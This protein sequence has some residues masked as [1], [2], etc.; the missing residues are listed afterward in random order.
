M[1]AFQLFCDSTSLAVSANA[2]PTRD[3][4]ALLEQMR[5]AVDAGDPA[6]ANCET[7]KDYAAI[8]F[9]AMRKLEYGFATQAFAT[10][11]AESAHALRVLDVGSGVVPLCNWM[12]RR[13]HEVTA[14]DPARSDIEFLISSD[15]NAF[16]GS[17]VRY[18]TGRAE[19]LPFPDESFDV[20]TCISVLEHVA[21]GNDRLALWEIARV[22]KP[23]GH[24]IL[25][26]DVA[27]A[28]REQ[29][30][31]QLW[32]ADWRR[33]AQPFS[34]QALGRLLQ[35]VGDCLDVSQADVPDALAS[36][37][38]ET[39]HAF[40][41]DTQAHDRR[42]DAVREYV[43]AGSVL[44]RRACGVGVTRDEAV[45]AYLEGQ[46][47][48]EERLVYFQQHAN[49]RLQLVNQLDAQLKAFDGRRNPANL[50]ESAE[51]PDS[52]TRTLARLELLEQRLEE[53]AGR[54][55][56]PGQVDG[57]GP[58]DGRHDAPGKQFEQQNELRILRSQLH[59][60][61][62][63]AE[64][65]LRVIEEQQRALD[66]YRR[67]RPRETLARWLAPRIG[68]LY[69][70]PPRLM[71]IPGHYSRKAP[72]D[73]PPRLSIVTPTFNQAQFVERTIQSVLSQGYGS[74]EYIIQ[75]GGST[76]E[77][78]DILERYRES[79]RHVESGPDGGI[80]G[81]LNRGFTR[82]TGEII[83][84]LNSDDFLLPGALNYVASYFARYPEVDVVYGH[85][86]VVDEYDGEV[87]R[88]VLPPH[89]D[90]ALSW[91][92]YVP[93]ET[94]FWRRRI[95]DKVGGAV[96]ES[97]R[98]A[99]DWDLLLRFRDAGARITRLP[100]FLGAF[101]VHPHQ[102]TSS[103]IE[104][105]G[106]EEMRRLRTRTLGRQVTDAE[107]AR[108]LQPYFRRHIICHKLYRLGVFRY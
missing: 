90:E 54:L 83:A 30:G 22:L 58:A 24:L 1:T 61:E 59:A 88:W 13:G 68:V 18:E 21:P 66:A 55:S 6:W 85:R 43:A 16:Y 57:R 7:I 87:G 84:Y 39:V 76:D 26:L 67:T 104:S 72:L 53:L 42:I 91:G 47:A 28:L 94:L 31:E 45:K 37:D 98:F 95:W 86:V 10:L 15:V 97:F 20:A 106:R 44:R 69:Q 36:L 40:W 35:Y 4:Y 73:A 96:D 29:P 70:Y 105:V 80:A 12:S 5:Q 27:P 50:S 62:A 38:W 33:H 102:K 99:V 74:L 78:L 82:A 32:P 64:A 17:S 93:Q 63:T 56:V 77:T 8:C 3:F 100:R 71:H 103:E 79:L 25:T 52:T 92:D 41:R 48:L 65:R 49:E 2:S 9:W 51:P 108:A 107:V 60:A 23:G 75:D 19:Q 14:I 81:G 89:D 101:R 34:H 11:E 46:S